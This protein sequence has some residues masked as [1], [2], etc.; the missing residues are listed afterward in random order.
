[1]ADVRSQNIT[2]VL[3]EKRT[4]PPSPEFSRQAHIKSMAEYE[5]LWRE[6]RDQPE[7]FWARYASELDWF[8]RWDKVLEWKEPYA[9]WFVGGSTN[10]SHNC[11]D[12]HLN[13]WRK[14][15]AA[16]VWEGEPGDSR[17]L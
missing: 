4:F 10:L 1:M 11:L 7:S 12:R 6:A 5:Q 17:V 13:G 3:Q 2:S 9:Q 16:I 15:K 14:N 8:K